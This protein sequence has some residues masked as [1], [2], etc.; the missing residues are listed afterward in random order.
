V[1]QSSFKGDV[2]VTDRDLGYEALL[3][4]TL[5]GDGSISVGIL[6]NEGASKH[7]V[8]AIAKA[9]ANEKKKIAVEKLAVGL[10]ALSGGFV[11]KSELVT[12]KQQKERINAA[13]GS[14]KSKAL[15][16]LEIATIHEFGLGHNPERSFIRAWFDEKKDENELLIKKI[17]EQYLAGKI[18]REQGLDLLGVR[19]VASVQ[20]RIRDRIEPPLA[21][22]TEDRKGSSVPLIDTGQLRSSITFKVNK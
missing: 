10:K 1:V 11:S 5:F 17:A 15:T 22:S 8:R 18:T 4:R 16:V 12:G 7:D 20:K 13:K 3:K 2:K 6:A 14:A 9:A 21:K 19:F